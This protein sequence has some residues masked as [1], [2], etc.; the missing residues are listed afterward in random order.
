MKQ[1]A[2]RHSFAKS[3]NES[4]TSGPLVVAEGV[5]IPL[6]AFGLIN[7]DVG[8]FAA[9]RQADIIRCKILVNTVCD[10]AYAKPLL[11]GSV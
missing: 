11:I 2:W 10:L 6:S 1:P 9:H 4:Q 8:R 5:D 3:L 7:A